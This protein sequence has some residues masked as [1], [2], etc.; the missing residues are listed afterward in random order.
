MK[1]FVPVAVDLPRGHSAPAQELPGHPWLLLEGGDDSLLEV[2]KN[3][4]VRELLQQ[5]I[6]MKNE[7]VF[8][9]RLKQAKTNK[10]IMIA[11]AWKGKGRLGSAQSSAG[12]SIANGFKGPITQ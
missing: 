10:L 7:N 9:F 11:R 1:P 5:K 12:Q 8:S 4:Y 3:R 2:Q 6:A